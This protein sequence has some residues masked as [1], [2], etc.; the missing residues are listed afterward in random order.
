MIHPDL[1]LITSRLA[2]VPSEMIHHCA[3]AIVHDK[4]L[5]ESDLVW[6]LASYELSKPRIHQVVMSDGVNTTE[7]F[8]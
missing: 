4:S 6:I 3:N 2:S 8:A 1:H 5:T 7:S